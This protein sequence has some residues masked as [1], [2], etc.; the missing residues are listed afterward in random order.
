MLALNLSWIEARARSTRV[1]YAA[2][3]V[4]A[5]V[6]A[7][8]LFQGVPAVLRAQETGDENAVRTWLRE[9]ANRLDTVESGHG[10]T[11][12]EPLRQTVGSARLVALGEATHGSREFFQLKHRM[13]EFLVNEMAFNV[14]AMETSMPE[15]FD[16]NQPRGSAP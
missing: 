3:V 11:D 13:L 10:F 4:T 14:F 2:A 1:A 8:L 6:V 7:A 15:A 16:I 9:N 12:L 5:A